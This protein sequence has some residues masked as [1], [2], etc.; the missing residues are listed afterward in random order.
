MNKIPWVAGNTLNLAIPLQLIT[1]NEGQ[2]VKEDYYP[3]EGSE[4]H[5]SVN[6][7]YKR[8][9][10]PCT[11]SGNIVSFTDDGS[12]PVGK[13]GV[14]ITVKEPNGQNRRYFECNDIEIYECTGS[15]NAMPDG[16]VLLDAA[17]FIQGQ[18]GDKGDAFTYDD[19]TPEEIAELQRPATEAAS[20]ANE[21]A[22]NANNKATEAERVNAEL[23][24]TTLTVTN[25][26]GE[27]VSVDTKGDKGDPGTT[28]YNEL[29]NKPDLSLKLDVIS[30]EELNQIFPIN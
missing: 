26:N 8:R 17:I 14:E 16:Q 10:Y 23:S 22:E 2:E 21:A 28:D 3:P 29:Q 30:D 25:R 18:K 19:F 9:K 24:G 1:K 27:S 12:L 13:Y 4:V 7:S 15:L 6:N 5:A 11:V 20:A